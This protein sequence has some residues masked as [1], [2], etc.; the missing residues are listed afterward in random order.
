MNTLIVPTLECPLE[1][2][3]VFIDSLWVFIPNESLLESTTLVTMCCILSA[4]KKQQ[5]NIFKQQSHAESWKY[6]GTFQQ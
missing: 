4:A 3:R 5:E 1:K 6:M 2:H